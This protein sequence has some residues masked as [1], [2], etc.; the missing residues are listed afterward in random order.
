MAKIIS[1]VWSIIRGSIAGTTYLTTP[2]GMII[3]RQRTRPVNPLT[4]NQEFARGALAQ[5]VNDWGGLTQPERTA[6]DAYATGSGLFA[7]GRQAM[8]SGQ[9]VFNYISAQGILP[10]GATQKKAAP[11]FAGKPNITAAQDALSAG[12]G[13]AVT[14][15]NNSA[16]EI[17]V[18]G[19]ISPMFEQ[20]RNFW[21]GPWNVDN[22]IKIL[23][24]AGGAN[25]TMEFTTTM[26]TDKIYFVRVHAVS[27]DDTANLQGNVV[28]NTLVIRCLSETV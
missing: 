10:A 14:V 1:P 28:S 15:T 22:G 8:V 20:T 5:A 9:Q 25:A 24:I 16:M 21:N 11:D 7:T 19:V 26:L 23:Q 17:M 4:K 3:G 2:S 18:Y 12:T 27:E 13:V 6:W